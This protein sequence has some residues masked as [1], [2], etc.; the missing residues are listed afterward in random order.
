[1]HVSLFHRVK[2]MLKLPLKYY[3]ESGRILPPIWLYALL[4]FFCLDWCAFI[5]SLASRAQTEALLLYFYPHGESLGL[6]L[7]SSFPLVIVVVAISQRERLWKHDYINWCR[8][9]IPAMLLGVS[10]AFGVQVYHA[11]KLHWNFEVVTAVKISVS[12]VA[13]YVLCRSRHL[14]WMVK[15][16]QAPSEQDKPLSNKA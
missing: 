5:F 6:A 7:I 2:S 13:F 11:I 3:D 1:M 15:D 8:W 4:A 14:H 9:L 12:L 16:W 10:C